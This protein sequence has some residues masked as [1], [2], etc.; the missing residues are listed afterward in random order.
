[1][2]DRRKPQTARGRT[3]VDQ[4][5]PPRA[6]GGSRRPAEKGGLAA[7]LREDGGR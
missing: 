4:A 3:G 7:G 6:A 2:V 1:M 5:M